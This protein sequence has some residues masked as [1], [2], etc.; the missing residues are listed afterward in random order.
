[1][2]SA[3]LPFSWVESC[4]HRVIQLFPSARHAWYS[5]RIVLS[6]SVQKRLPKRQD[7]LLEGTFA[8]VLCAFDEADGTDTSELL[9][10]PGLE[11]AASAA[12]PMAA[13]AAAFVAAG[14]AD[15]EALA[16]D[17]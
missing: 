6:S 10:F 14:G 15:L 8:D 17:C 7:S 11:V 16:I 9:R 1:M 3:D 2:S 5:A 12:A 13:I 4:L